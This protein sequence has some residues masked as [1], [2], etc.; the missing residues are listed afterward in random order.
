MRETAQAAFLAA[1]AASSDPAAAPLSFAEL[2]RR[3]ALAQ[4]SKDP[5][6]SPLPI[7]PYFFKRTSFMSLSA[8]S[9]LRTPSALAPSETVGAPA[10]LPSS[11]AEGVAPEPEARGVGARPPAARPPPSPLQQPGQAAAAAAMSPRPAARTPRASSLER[12][13]LENS[14]AAAVRCRASSAAEA[15]PPPSLLPAFAAADGSDRSPSLLTLRFSDGGTC[16]GSRN[17]L[18]AAATMDG[19]VPPTKSGVGLDVYV[20]AV[21]A[22]SDAA[23]LLLPAYEAEGLLGLAVAML[24]NLPALFLLRNWAEVWRILDV[25]LAHQVSAPQGPRHTECEGRTL[26]RTNSYPFPPPPKR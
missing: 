15:A 14:A 7:S 22:P 9:V 23:P 18:N 21:P 25:Y 5:S 24:P 12:I 19:P 10:A 16:H 20:D 8:P 4:P 13:A 3:L 2:M 6:I 17:S 11:E 26:W 1:L